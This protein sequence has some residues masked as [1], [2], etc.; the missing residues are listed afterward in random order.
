MS[1]IDWVKIIGY[2]L[3]AIGKGMGASEAVAKASA[4]FGVSESAIRNHGGF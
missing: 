2:I 3:I 1:D 4:K